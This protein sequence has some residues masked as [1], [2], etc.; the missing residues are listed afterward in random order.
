MREVG[1]YHL[2]LIDSQ[3]KKPNQLKGRTDTNKTVILQQ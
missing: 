2:V 3:G 1:T